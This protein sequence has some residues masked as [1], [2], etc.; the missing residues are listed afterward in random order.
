MKSDENAPTNNISKAS[1]AKRN[2]PQYDRS[3]NKS[4]ATNYEQKGDNS[5]IQ[6]KSHVDQLEEE[7]K[8]C[9]KTTPYEMPEDD[10]NVYTERID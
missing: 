4:K 2:D 1:I 7:I 5:K 8:D 9:Y 6:E 10:L 3:V